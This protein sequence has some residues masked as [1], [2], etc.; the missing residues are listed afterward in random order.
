MNPSQISKPYKHG[1]R[2][3]CRYRQDGGAWRWAPSA[4]TPEEAERA[5]RGDLG[6]GPEQQVPQ[7]QDPPQD[8]QQQDPT[9]R[10]QD[11]GTRLEG[12]YPHRGAV[13]YRILSGRGR[14]W[15]PSAK[16]QAR[17]LRLAEETA[18]QH[19]REGNL[20]IREGIAA[21]LVDRRAA[22]CRDVTLVGYQNALRAFFSPVLDLPLARLTT[23]RGADLYESAKSTRAV[24]SAN[25]YLRMAKAL[26][27]WTTEKGWIQESPIAGVK[28][29]GRPNRG[30]P[31]FT[32]DEAR[33]FYAY[34]LR[35]ALAG[36]DGAAAA[37]LAVS[38]GLRASEVTSRTV[39]DLDDNGRILR[40]ANNAEISYRTKTD[41]ARTNVIPADLRPMLAQRAR[42][43]LPGAYLLPDT[44]GGRRSRQWVYENVKRLCREAN[45]PQVCPHSLRG[46]SATAA[47]AAGALPELVAQ[48]LGHSNSSMTLNHY[49]APGTSEAAQFERANE[50]L[51][52]RSR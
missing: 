23:R 37:L 25:H 11:G 34:A 51:T 9:A 31:Q 38:M 47:A 52:R 27:A 6:E 17:A 36:D 24:A 33:A 44:R 20:T 8:A 48:M 22:G 1:T 21:F 18:R 30:K 45:L 41:K 46:V 14:S 16:T 4:A 26:L 29:T 7:Q 10:T 35:Q 15:A 19:A 39:R 49:I 12:P 2:Y 5:A 28:K 42:D 32:L 13:R 43:K 40:V 3:R 50:V